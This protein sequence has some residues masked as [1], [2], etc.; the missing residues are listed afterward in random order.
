MFIRSEKLM[1]HP[2]SRYIDKARSL[3]FHF[4][5]LEERRE[6]LPQGVDQ[7]I[8]LSEQDFSGILQD[9]L[10]GERQQHS[11]TIPMF[12]REEA[13]ASCSSAGLRAGG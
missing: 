11:F 5:F 12:P 6:Y 8:T 9:T 2:V 1:L 4:V 13:A 10:D 3:G 7:L